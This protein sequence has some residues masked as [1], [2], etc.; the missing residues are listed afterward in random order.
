MRGNEL[1]RSARLPQADTARVV[2]RQ[3]QAK[4]PTLAHLTHRGE[5]ALGGKEV[6]AAALIIDAELTP[7]GSCRTMLP[8]PHGVNLAQIAAAR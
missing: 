4:H 1:R 3:A 6:H 8:A 5:A 2:K 7:V